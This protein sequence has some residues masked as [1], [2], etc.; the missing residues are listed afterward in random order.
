MKET[1]VQNNES[2]VPSLKDIID[3]KRLLKKVDIV[4]KKLNNNGGSKPPS[5]Q[6]II[7]SKSLLKKV[8]TPKPPQHEQEESDDEND[9]MK[10]FSVFKNKLSKF[11]N[12]AL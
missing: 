1:Q 4:N 7:A 5:L 9:P 2:K 10:Q 6:D 3:S 11:F 8:D 12:A